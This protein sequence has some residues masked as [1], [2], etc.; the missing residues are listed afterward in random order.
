[1]PRPNVE[2]MLPM[3]PEKEMVTQIRRP[4]LVKLYCECET[5]FEMKEMMDDEDDD[6]HHE[7]DD[8]GEEDGSPNYPSHLMQ[9]ELIADLKYAEDGTR[10][11]IA[12][13]AVFLRKPE[14]A[15]GLVPQ[16]IERDDE[17]SNTTKILVMN[18]TDEDASTNGEEVAGFLF[19]PHV[20]E[21][22]DEICRLIKNSKMAA[23]DV[24]SRT[25]DNRQIREDDGPVITRYPAVMASNTAC[26][27]I[28]APLI[29]LNSDL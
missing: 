7:E 16:E 3:Q 5:H 28:V 6:V 23:G 24:L 8:G 21:E 11:A 25:P 1:M 18:E 13:D 12:R 4:P 27:P 19:D 26:V 10:K 14:N 22:E 15:F 17:E 29:I 9:N 20:Q 2:V